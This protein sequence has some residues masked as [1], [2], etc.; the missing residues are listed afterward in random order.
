MDSIVYHIAGWE[1]PKLKFM[2]KNSVPM[3][4]IFKVNMLDFEIR[5]CLSH[6]YY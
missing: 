4:L 2:N 6:F 3:N 1:L 5:N